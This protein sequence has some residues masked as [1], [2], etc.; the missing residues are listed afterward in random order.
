[1]ARRLSLILVLL[2]LAFICGC[3]G[4]GPMP[5]DVKPTFPVTGIVNID[6][7]PTK[8]VQLYLPAPGTEVTSDQSTPIVSAPAA[9]TD[10]N[11]KFAFSTYFQGDGLPE[12]DYV[13]A[14]YWTG[15]VMPNL[16]IIQDAE[17]KL[18]PIA[19]TFNQKYGYLNR[20][21]IKFKVEGGKS[22]DLGVLELTTA[23]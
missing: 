21:E 7:K 1:M 19:E 17:P 16:M 3:F 14:F 10:E 11:G 5:K 18:I 20:S 23:K 9:S 2:P 12:G 13:I 15:G 22:L 8:D 6:G 4:G